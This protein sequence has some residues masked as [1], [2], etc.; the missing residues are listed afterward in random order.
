MALSFLNTKVALLQTMVLV[1]CQSMNQ[2]PPP[3]P[4]SAPPAKSTKLIAAMFY[5]ALSALDKA[6]SGQLKK[7][8]LHQAIESGVE[9]DDWA[10]ES[11]D[12]GMIRWQSIFAFASIGL[13]R[14]G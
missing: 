3:E 12:S 7:S 4:A 9:L 5:A 11:Y 13:K 6:P 2:S 10:K 8:Q 14:A 1:W